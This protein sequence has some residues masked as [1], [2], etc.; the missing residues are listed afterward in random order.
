MKK[1][2]KLEKRIN[3]ERSKDFKRIIKL[4]KQ[5]PPKV[6]S[7]ETQDYVWSVSE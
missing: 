7:E 3:K 4:V 1:I 5:F 6:S 2:K